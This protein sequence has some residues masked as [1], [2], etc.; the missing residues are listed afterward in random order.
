[1][2]EAI[3]PATKDDLSEVAAL[4]RAA[5]AELSGTKGGRV[6]ARREG[7]V[8]PVEASLGD[9]IEDGAVETLVGTIDDVIVGYAVA[10]VQELPDGGR[11]ARLTD[12]YVQPE[13]REVGI[14]EL[15]LDT[16]LAWAAEG[17]CFGVDS[18]VLPGNRETKNFFESAGMVARAIIVHRALP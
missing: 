1:V 2:V 8:E 4:A 9:A 5:V 17:G 7:R 14:G 16:V 3:R 15:L 10:R 13:A 11:L 18:I 6:W 12:I